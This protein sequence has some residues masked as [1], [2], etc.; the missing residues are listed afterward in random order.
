MVFARTGALLMTIPPFESRNIPVLFKIGLAISVS[1][2]LFPFVPMDG[3][4]MQTNALSFGMGVIGEVTL[5]FL[6]GLMIQLLFAGIQLGGQLAGFQIGLAIANV[7]DPARGGQIPIL[8]QF[9]HL[10]AILLFMA[11]NAHH[12]FIQ[13][14]VESFHLVPP[15]Q[16]AFSPA[17]IELLL[18][19]AG[20][21][22]LIAIKIGAP[23]IV[24][25]IL[26]SVVLGLMARTVPH[27]QVFIV[28]I[29]LKILIG[30]LFIGFSL[31]YLA[32]YITQ[33]AHQS[34]AD[35]YGLIRLCAGGP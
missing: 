4:R 22:F 13:A 21:M 10:L 28:G 35:V 12:G 33:M 30:L 25:L 6:V 18:E 32:A 5:G 14:V 9:N 20:R 11:I 3:Y 29:P 31:P 17:S 26:T 15:L 34:H 23:V 16:V 1:A 27:M 24:A 19:L 2:L 7:M 8:S